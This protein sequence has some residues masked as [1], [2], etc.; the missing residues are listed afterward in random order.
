MGDLSVG[1]S[2]I[3]AVDDDPGHA[4]ADGARPEGTDLD[5][6]TADGDGPRS[7][8]GRGR[9]TVA[10]VG[11]L[12]VVTV[13]FVWVLWSLWGP[14]DPLRPSNY[15]DNFY[16]LQTRAMFHGHLWLANGSLGIEGFIHGGHTYTYFGLF[17]SIIRMPILALTGSLDGK[18]T[19]SSL[20]IAWFLTGLFA[21][22][23]LWRVRV[24]IRGNASLGWAEAS[25]FG[26]LVSTVMGG[27]IWMLLGAT[28]FVFNEDIAWSVCLTTGALFTLLGVVERPGWG[29]VVASGIL[30]LCAN[31]D[32]ATTGWATALAAG[33]IAVWFAVG[34]G[35][36]ENRRWFVPMLGA[37][38][39]PLVISCAVNYSKFGVLFGVSNFEQVWTH[40]NA[41]RRRFLAANHNAEEGLIFAPT[42]L[43]TYL[44]PDGL[45]L[46]S[47]FPFIT[48]PATPPTAVS[49]VLFDRL[50]RT[51]SLPSSTPLLFVLSGWGLVTAFRPRPVGR[52]ALTRLLLLSAGS[53]GAALM[54]WG[55]IAPRY[56]ADFCPFLTLASAV[57]MVDI[58]RR[59]EGR[60]PG[61]R[62]TALGVIAAVA[63]FSIAANVGMA[64]TPN[65]EWNS[66]QVLHYVE[67]QKT[68][69]DV[70]GHPLASQVVR[71]SSLPP[72][73]PA[74]QL[75]VV[76]ACDG[77][78]ISNGED[79]ST[80]PSSQYA[81]TT[82]MVVERGHQFQH[83]FRLTVRPVSGGTETMALV[84]AGPDTVSVSATA[85]AVPDRVRLTFGLYGPG[86][87]SYGNPF[88]VPTHT[89]HD[90][91]V[92]TDPAKHVVQAVMDGNTN[93]LKYVPVA[94]PIVGRP[95]G[96]S[97]G[98]TPALS[99]VDT[100][101]S[102]PE[103]TLCRSLDK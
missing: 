66:T 57:A 11:G 36:K 40:V 69:S 26:I 8:G 95:S 58:W 83:T 80:V 61:V 67:T 64:I 73:G 7:A 38:L 4:D 82:W 29:R 31:L 32:R 10:C 2:G 89:T 16:D 5:A 50:Y 52:V 60:A 28:P 88:L 78:Y 23:L 44:R 91:V 71:G 55:Y 47:V 65:E 33:L 22:L 63:A 62:G 21:T 51:A 41:Y 39:V 34:R 49:G 100:T 24:L 94:R 56:L 68:I 86:P 3:V 85:T 27:T 75:Y 15:Q 37:G 43:L 1:S 20:L 35:G 97:Q 72:W 59:L 90:L 84:D 6:A 81:R 77:L 14:V 17:P 42:N 99:M 101:S 12:A 102:S 92:I 30:V 74:D 53:A 70:T 103:P 87:P 19:P 96:H 48:L 25:A 98:P 9:F 45:R 18:L 79:Y 76:G 46:T 13:P 93:L 54:L